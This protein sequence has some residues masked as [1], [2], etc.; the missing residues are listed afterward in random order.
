[1]SPARILIC[2]D[3]PHVVRLVAAKLR[4]AGMECLSAEDGTEAL[5]I[6]LS[7]RPDLIVSDCQMPGLTGLEMAARLRAAE[8]SNEP[9]PGYEGG[10]PVLLLTGRGFA[11]TPQ[12]L[13]GTNVRAVMS[14]PFSP[15]EILATVQRLL[16]ERTSPMPAAVDEGDAITLVAPP[17]RQP[18]PNICP[19]PFRCL[20]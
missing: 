14:K 9:A 3:E 10:T 19:E 20:P 4:N 15:R 12:D 13:E 8:Q 18:A 5:E 1:M 16:N 2:D 7:H 11:V 17:D 6:A